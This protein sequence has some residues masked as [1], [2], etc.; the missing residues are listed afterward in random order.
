MQYAKNQQV[1]V[2]VDRNNVHRGW[3]PNNPVQDW[4][5][6]PATVMNYYPQYNNMSPKVVCLVAR[7]PFVEF[8]VFPVD[9]GWGTPLT[10]TVDIHKVRPL[11]GDVAAGFPVIR[12]LRGPWGQGQQLP[13]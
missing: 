13:W 9:A 8:P 11:E 7:H 3:G 10:H 1:E 6:T 12:R 5:W 2:L 4:Q